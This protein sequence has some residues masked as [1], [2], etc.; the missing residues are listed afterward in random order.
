MFQ[1]PNDLRIKGNL[2][3]AACPL[4]RCG[5]E[6]GMN[7]LVRFVISRAGGYVNGMCAAQLVDGGSTGTMPASY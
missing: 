4:E 1:D 2:P 3:S 5:T 7:G 6:D